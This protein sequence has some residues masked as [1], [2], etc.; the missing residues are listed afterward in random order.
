MDLLSGTV[1]SVEVSAGEIEVEIMFA[2]FWASLFHINDFYPYSLMLP[3]RI[4]AH[5][6]TPLS[7]ASQHCFQSGRIQGYLLKSDLPLNTLKN[8]CSF[9]RVNNFA[10]KLLIHSRRQ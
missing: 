7:W 2:S 8:L 5:V 6:H 10:P 4:P 9:I 1:L 3:S